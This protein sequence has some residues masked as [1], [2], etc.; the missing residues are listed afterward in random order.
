MSS[1]EYI[2]KVIKNIIS[3]T[4]KS[5]KRFIG[6]YKRYLF[7]PKLPIHPMGKVLLHLGCGDMKSDHYI[8]VDIKSA[9][10]IHYVQ[11]VTDLSIFKNNYADLIYACHVLEHFAPSSLNK[12]LIEWHRVL[13]PGGVLR[14]SVPDFDKLIELYNY[15]G[16]GVEHIVYP[17][18]GMNDGY[19]SHLAIFNY[20]FLE[21][22]L[23]KAGFKN[24]RTWDPKTAS[25]YN[26][27]DWASRGI[28][29]GE[30]TFSI[31][32]NVEAEK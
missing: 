18:V 13:K 30:K 22:T 16:K 14:L 32:L 4:L 8:N 12:I 23:K 9:P 27:D 3:A 6:V 28:Q 1:V 31:S 11:T 21:E 2:V 5:L 19:A 20:S 15:S 7:T 17:L 25:N 24:I 26:F 10:H 29:Y